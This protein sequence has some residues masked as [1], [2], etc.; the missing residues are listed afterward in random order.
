MRRATPRRRQ[1]VSCVFNTD[2]DDA[3]NAPNDPKKS[4]GFRRL[5]RW[6]R[7]LERERLGIPHPPKAAHGGKWKRKLRQER[8]AED[9][10]S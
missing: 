2:K 3:V 7:F 10:T 1:M 9:G 8:A 4:Y 6:Q 5:R